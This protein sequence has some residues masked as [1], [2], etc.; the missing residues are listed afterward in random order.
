MWPNILYLI[1]PFLFASLLIGIG[2]RPR[3]PKIIF[4]QRNRTFVKMFFVFQIAFVGLPLWLYIS[5]SMYREQFQDYGLWGAFII[6]ALTIYGV[7]HVLLFSQPYRKKTKVVGGEEFVRQY[8]R[9]QADGELEKTTLGWIPDLIVDGKRYNL[10]D[11]GRNLENDGTLLP[12]LAFDK[13]GKVVRDPVLMNKLIQCFYLADGVVMGGGSTGQ[14]LNGYD[15]VRQLVKQLTDGLHKVDELVAPLNAES[16][17]ELSTNIA[18]FKR[19]LKI[20]LEFSMLVLQDWQIEAQWEYDRGNAS[21]KEVAYEELLELALQLKAIEYARDHEK[22]IRQCWVAR[23]K[24]IPPMEQ[25]AGTPRQEKELRSFFEVIDISYD[26]LADLK[27]WPKKGPI[28]KYEKMNAE[29]EL[30]WRERLEWVER[31]DGWIAEGF[32]GVELERK[33]LNWQIEQEGL[34]LPEEAQKRLRKKG[35]LQ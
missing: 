1:G 33:K 8:T 28:I 11:Y 18:L 2:F 34:V 13:S 19:G 15:N 5:S 27:N 30:V 14:R 10:V 25:Y 6:L 17:S 26:A 12:T 20:S 24:L 3:R 4:A 32:S 29:Q 9:C 7:F 16:N 22:E 31:V 23:R 21:I 35:V